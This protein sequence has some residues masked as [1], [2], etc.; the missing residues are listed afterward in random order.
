MMERK[1]YYLDNLVR[2]KEVFSQF[3]L[4]SWIFI[5]DCTL[6]EG[7]QIVSFSVE[8]K[9]RIAHKLDE[10]GVPV[11]QVGIPGVSSTDKEIIKKLKKENLKAKLE[12]VSFTYRP[13]WKED[14]DACLESGADSIDLFYPVS[15]DKLKV[16][17]V[18]EEEMIDVC[19]RAIAYVKSQGVSDIVFCPFP[20]VRTEMSILKK[21]IGLAEE[22]GATRILIAD[23]YGTTLPAAM[24]YFI[25]KIKEF[26]KIPL[27]IHCHNDLGLALANTLAAV[28]AGVEAVD[29]TING[30]GDRTGN[31]CLD[32][33]IIALQA[34]YDFDPGIK[35]EKLYTLSKLLE[36]ITEIKLPFGKPLV[37]DN[38]FVHRHDDDVKGSVMVPSSTVPIEPGIVGNKRRILVGGEYT[39]PYTIKAKAK[40]FGVELSEE[41]IEKILKKVRGMLLGKKESLSD[42]EYLC[43]IKE[44][45]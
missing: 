14:V 38:A 33:V 7:D 5:T 10:L 39:G 17:N 4:P 35:T 24:R 36:E 42:E 11:I 1:Y 43:I 30:L 32:E 34:F 26:T 20:A 16:M 9:I 19:T 15:E 45:K 28:E 18:S 41:K 44:V 2:L 21:L 27:G 22:A 12:A 31:C 29:A 8:E 6:R 37:G 25:R 13:N 40:Q 23:T 3:N